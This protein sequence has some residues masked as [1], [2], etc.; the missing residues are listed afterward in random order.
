MANNTTRHLTQHMVRICIP[1]WDVRFSCLSKDIYVRW[2]PIKDFTGLGVTNH[3]VETLEAFGI[4]QLYQQQNLSG[5]AMNGQYI[6][7]NA[8]DY[9]KNIF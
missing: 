2:S 4:D 3:L 7:L 6:H 5:C 1:I 8:L 9:L